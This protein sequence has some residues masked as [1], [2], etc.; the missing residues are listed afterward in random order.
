MIYVI[1]A[2]GVITAYVTGMH[3]GGTIAATSIT[4]RITPPKH[5][6]RLS[7]IA[8]FLGAILLGTAVAQ[9]IST[10]LVDADPVLSSGTLTGSFYVLSA[11]LGSLVWNLFTWKVRLPSS[12][13]HSLIGAMVGAALILS[14]P[15]IVHWNAVLIKVVLA[16]VLSPLLGSIAGFLLFRLEQRILRN[17]TIVWAKRVNSLDIFSMLLLSLS[18]GSN[19][20]QKVTGLLA[21]A[22]ALG[23]GSLEYP[24]WLTI[25]IGA[26]LALG[27]V[28]GGY[29]MIRTVGL[30]ITKPDPDNAAVSELS[31][32]LV[33]LISSLAGI[34][35]SSTQVITG[36]IL[37]AGS[38]RSP[39]TV[40]W[41]VTKS[42]LISWV[43]TLPA[44]AACGALAMKLLTLAF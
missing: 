37:G 22:L 34:P 1:L 41:P 20:A 11:F 17:A 27:T 44:S 9:T 4:S 2:I 8:N 26:A 19:D 25:L 29:N 30:E 7:G 28:T 12:A 23:S 42:I 13:S 21:L 43:L 18:H 36:S 5:A 32:T 24:L 40:N 35:I 14:G 31:S 16:M 38:G 33:V 15:D 6:L 3:D 10:G 39:R